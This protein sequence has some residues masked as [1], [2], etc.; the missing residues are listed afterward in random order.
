MA[1]FFGTSLEMDAY[2]IGISIPLFVSGTL[3]S[4]LSYSMVTALVNKK[5]DP[6]GFSRFTTTMFMAIMGCSFT[7]IVLGMISA[8]LFINIFGQELSSKLRSDAI[9]ISRITWVA[10]GISIIIT[11]L[12][13][14]HNADKR[15]IYPAFC[16]VMPYLGMVVFAVIFGRSWGPVAVTWGLLAGSGF[17]V[18]ILFKNIISE[19][20]LSNKILSNW[21]EISGY[22]YKVPPMI[23]AGL[24]F[25]IFQV[26]DAYWAPRL[27]S[28]NLSYL[29][30]CQ[31]ILVSVGTLVIV[32]PSLV[33]V[34]HLSAAARDGRH[35]EFLTD[36][37]RAIRTI[38]VFGAPIGMITSILSVPI[39]RLLFE[40]GSFDSQATNGVAFLLPLMMTGMVA[41][42]CGVITFRAMF[43]KGDIIPASII[44]GIGGVIYFTLS[45]ILSSI[46]GVKGIGLAYL[47]TWWAIL[48]ASL[49]VLWRGKM[50]L[51][52][53]AGNYMFILKLVLSLGIT[54]VIINLGYR[55]F[56]ESIGDQQIL[57]LVIR[58][59]ISIGIGAFSYYIIA[60]QV[61]RIADVKAVFDSIR[62]S[63][64][65]RN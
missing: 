50:G 47:V 56:I 31:R 60:V 19:F 42:L 49:A 29:G 17:S 36:T 12:S 61:F 46:M 53:S 40:R 48:I 37:G 41:M 1:N 28:S 24:C 10:G 18:L 5:R 35:N 2:L 25:T 3:T 11:F 23:V 34:P 13:S 7:M 62:F 45:G 64:F 4:V 59:F 43:A 65:G 32:G 44:G 55:A 16:A 51:L 6:E 30:Y 9:I 20:V 14:V 33:L 8:P 21:T 38:L 58:V 26:V 22:F 39:L 27:G 57:D 15:F 63:V 52:L 54:S